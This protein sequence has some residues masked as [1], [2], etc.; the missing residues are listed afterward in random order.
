MKKNIT[1]VILFLLPLIMLLTFLEYKAGQM[2]NEY[3]LK[4]DLFNSK[5]SDV[6]V[7]FMGPS[8]TAKGINTDLIDAEAFNAASN[9]QTIY[10]DT[11]IVEAYLDDMPNLKMVVFNVFPPIMQFSLENTSAMSVNYTLSHYYH[12]PLQS[13][14]EFFD[15]RHFSV[16]MNMGYD[17]FM[18]ELLN[19]RVAKDILGDYRYTDTGYMKLDEEHLLLKEI[20]ETQ[21]PLMLE[22][23]ASVSS[24]ENKFIQNEK[25]LSE[26]I[27]KITERG[28]EVVLITTPAT[29]AYQVYYD[30]LYLKTEAFMNTVKDVKGVTCINYFKD[31]RFTQEDFADS[32]HLN[33]KGGIKIS[34]IINQDIINLK[35]NK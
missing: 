19:G 12:V 22:Q 23:Y 26:S 24:D 21:L 28:I 33:L 17:H 7:L 14:K 31:E 34:T 1:K 29:E 10:Y 25:Y 4:A 11:Q 35:N 2:D 30:A 6:E 32:S 3:K 27:A 9:M 18:N 20:E 13:L 8:Q 16:I 15:V 5:V